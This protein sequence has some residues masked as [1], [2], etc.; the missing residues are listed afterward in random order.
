M[1][2]GAFADQEGA[3][4]ISNL[5]VDGAPAD[6]LPG[7]VHF[8]VA[9]SSAGVTPTSFYYGGPGLCYDEQFIFYDDFNYRS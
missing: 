8:P 6:S 3:A 5:A 9:Y 2:N 7:I 1:G 4:S